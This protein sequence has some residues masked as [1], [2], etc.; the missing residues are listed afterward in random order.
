M[1]ERNVSAE[2]YWLVNF[3]LMLINLDS[4]RK[5]K[6]SRNMSFLEINRV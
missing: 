6:S 2:F 5:T 4:Q 3:T 1:L